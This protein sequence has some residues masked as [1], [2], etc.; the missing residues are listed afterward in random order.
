[1]SSLDDR[2]CLRA[3]ADIRRKAGWLIVLVQV[4]TLVTGLLASWGLLW[5]DSRL[6][7]LQQHLIFHLVAQAL[8]YA[9]LI[10]LWSVSITFMYLV[11]LRSD[12]MRVTRSVLRASAAAIWFPP[13]LVVLYAFYPMVI[14]AAIVLVAGTTR[15][16][17]SQRLLIRV[18]TGQPLLH[19]ELPRG[20]LTRASAPGLAATFAIHAS[21][22][23]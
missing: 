5:V 14:A 3:A 13:A 23:A 18:E 16:L 2:N 22:L 11:P 15:L 10:W 21:V 4:A 6:A 7:R 12:W 8:L 9:L 20:V 17:I 1:M 19:S